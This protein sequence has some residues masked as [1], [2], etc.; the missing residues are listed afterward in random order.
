MG[1]LPLGKV[2]DGPNGYGKTERWKLRAGK[3]LNRTA[4]SRSCS[5]GRKARGGAFPVLS[6]HKTPPECPAW[7]RGGPS[8][9]PVRGPAGAVSLAAPPVFQLP[10]TAVSPGS[11]VPWVRPCRPA[12]RRRSASAL[13]RRPFP[14]R[15]RSQPARLPAPF[16]RAW[17]VPPSSPC[18][19]RAERSGVRRRSRPRVS[20]GRP[21]RFEYLCFAP[22]AA[23][24]RFAA[25]P[26]FFGTSGSAAGPLG[27]HRG[28]A[29]GVFLPGGFPCR[30][31]R[32][33][34]LPGRL[35]GWRCFALRGACRR[36]AALRVG[37][38]R[39]GAV[40]GRWA[41][42]GG[43]GSAFHRRGS[44]LPAAPVPSG[45]ARFRSQRRVQAFC[46]PPG[47][48]GTFRGGPGPLGLHRGA[49]KCVSP[50]GLSPAG[51]AGP[52][53]DGP[54]SL[55]EARA[56]VLPP[57]GWD[58]DVQ[59]VC[60]ACTGAR[61][62]GVSPGGHPLPMASRRSVPGWPCFAL[63]NRVQ[64]FCRPPGG[65]GTFSGGPGPPGLHRGARKCLSPAGSPAGGAAP[66][67]SGRPPG[68]GA[69]SP[70]AARTGGRSRP[71]GG[72]GASGPRGGWRP[73]PSP[74]V[75]LPSPS[76]F[77]PPYI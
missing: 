24:R 75:F 23:Y 48:I 22:R 72:P 7:S 63:Q 47:G 27:L 15:T 33:G 50:E 4:R 18:W 17:P 40:R 10:F 25:L 42:T 34:S 74:A 68:M 76:V 12:G 39:S 49:G 1:R 54:V 5:S 26:A 57:S 71:G 69:V 46:R 2:T 6:R 36:F 41:C 62:R 19:N 30:W 8:W 43:R 53:R 29:G 32:A 67:R 38:G 56:G 21:L 59:E 20:P 3:P 31:R 51:G 64:A 28:R 65:I 45:M 77:L 58:W 66:V 61:S 16:R 11:R 13:G 55:S 35:L 73:G 60:G 44:P 70:P 52:F 37:L 14:A 9:R